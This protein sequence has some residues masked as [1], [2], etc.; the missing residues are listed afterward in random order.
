MA[1]PVALMPESIQ[2]AVREGYEGP[3]LNSPL[4]TRISKQLCAVRGASSPSVTTNSGDPLPQVPHSRSLV[5][6]SPQWQSKLTA[7]ATA[8][9]AR[10][11]TLA[12]CGRPHVLEALRVRQ[13]ACGL[14]AQ[15]PFWA[16]GVMTHVFLRSLS[17]ERRWGMTPDH[18]IN[19]VLGY[20]AVATVALA[21][22]RGI[23]LQLRDLR[24][25][26]DR[27]ASAEGMPARKDKMPARHSSG[28]GDMGPASLGRCAALSAGAHRRKQ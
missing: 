4:Y 28:A 16:G 3:R 20:G 2:A 18:L 24:R 19:L 17:R 9:T 11:E 15:L 1:A 6:V 23:Q 14:P 27:E 12:S 8:S 7:T 13:S 25:S 26:D 5:E 21:V 22:L 10:G